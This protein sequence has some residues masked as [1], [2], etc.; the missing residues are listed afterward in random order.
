MKKSIVLYSISVLMFCFGV[1]LAQYNCWGSSTYPKLDNFCVTRN[2]FANDIPDFY[3][4]TFIF[5]SILIAV[6]TFIKQDD[7]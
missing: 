5:L 1:Y 4:A 3:P 2:G 6:M 7:L